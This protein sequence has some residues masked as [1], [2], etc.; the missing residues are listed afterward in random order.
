MAV[1]QYGLTSTGFVIKRQSVILSEIQSAL[2]TA[3][4]SNVNLLPQGVLGQI[5][6]IYS[7]REALV[8]ELAQAVYT[9]QYPAGAEGTAVDN[10]LALN[11]L[12][13]LPATPTV[14][15]PTSTAGVPG[16]VFYGTAGTVIPAASI[17]SVLGNAN[18]QFTTD[19]AVT[20]ASALS[21]VQQLTN[22]GG[23]PTS[24]KFQLQIVAPTGV[25][26]TSAAASWDSQA[27]VTVL[28]FAVAPT[29]GS[30][31]I[32]T[33]LAGTVRTTTPL[34]WNATAGAIQSALSTAGFP[35][36]LVTGSPTAGPVLIDWVGSANAEPLVNL[37]DTLLSY[38]ATPTAGNLQISLN[39][40]PVPL[41]VYNA[42]A[43]VLQ[44]AI[45]T[46]AG[47]E[48]VLVTGSPVAGGGYLLNWG[49]VTVPTVLVTTQPTGATVTPTATSS[50][51]NGGTVSDS[52][53]AVVN[54]L[55]DFS[56]PN[57]PY[58]DIAITGS[59][60]GSLFVLT[61]G[62][63]S[64]VA[65]N[66]I[67]GSMAE[68]KFSA[69]NS[70]LQV[71]PTVINLNVTEAV[72][73]TPAQGIGS[74]TCGV[75]GPNY[76]ASG[77]LSVIGSPISGWT[78][79]TNPLDCI[80]GTN[81]E[82]D[83]AAL[84]RRLTLL[85]ANANG[86]LSAIVD[87]VQKVTGVVQA[88]GFENT[89][90]AADQIIT[91]TG[92]PVSGSFT[93]SL[94]GPGGGVLTTAAVPWNAAANTQ[95]L[96]FSAVPVSGYF[97]LT[98]GLQ[99][100][101]HIAYNA[102][103]A[104]VQ[105]AVDALT[106]YSGTIVTGTFAA[107]FTMAFG[108]TPQNTAVATNFLAGATITVIPSLQSVLNDLA[109][110]YQALATGSYGSGFTVS[111]NGS[112][113]GQP[114]LLG[115]TTNALTGVSAILV[116]FGR[117]GKSFEIVVNDNNGQASNLNVA[118]AILGAKPAGIESFGT[119]TEITTDSFGNEYIIK[120]SRPTQVPIYIVVTLITDL[121]TSTSPK[122]NPSSIA[123]IQ[124][125]LVTIGS[126]FPVGGQVIGFGT[127][128]LIGAFN[129]VPGINSYTLTFGT[130]PNPGGNGTIQL[131]A[132][133]VAQFEDFNIT[134]SYS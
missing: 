95:S 18:L 64:P 115:T 60:S 110:Y 98:F 50:L 19:L 52:L 4:G 24:G 61:F 133:Q 27:A 44:T 12:K 15:A 83:T 80:T 13:R 127:N 77:S 93:L 89:S 56:V 51:D 129:T 55:F 116:A 30:F 3:F 46:V 47:Y 94:T 29:T 118:N 23:I 68:N 6:S 86:P 39:G 91:F 45:Q 134:V 63:Y 7:E 65:P 100:T 32:A 69:V 16:L 49:A 26:M 84:A 31:R 76:V 109:P 107:G 28:N 85:S 124:Q 14:T 40:S 20:I 11:N 121:T 106:G 8:W 43:S 122:F 113:G 105:A 42:A 1:T 90:G 67:S 72:K 125:D 101:A 128:G 57:Y 79:V 112:A 103:A 2:Q 81:I 87:K 131:Q 88:I 114:Q 102:T 17:I 59:F 53:Q 104:A 9:S 111:F 22:Y 71:G 73:G 96:K 36:A 35:A 70:T 75:K 41:C 21:E 10:I 130:S 33:R 99:T 78:S 123:A 58:T 62:A 34:A 120:F 108:V 126:A 48:T 132:E 82:T 74:A 5:S 37:N 54:N 66:P 38:S 92:T 117:P 25:T 119:V 97:T